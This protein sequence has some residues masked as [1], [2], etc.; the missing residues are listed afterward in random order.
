MS[1]KQDE[2][3]KHQLRHIGQKEPDQQTETTAKKE[4]TAADGTKKARLLRIKQSGIQIKK[5]GARPTYQR[6]QG[7]THPHSFFIEGQ[8]ICKQF[9]EN[10]NLRLLDQN[11]VV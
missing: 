5:A 11:H 2:L 4:I 3:K 10:S 9:C 1:G 7:L 6:G 8:M